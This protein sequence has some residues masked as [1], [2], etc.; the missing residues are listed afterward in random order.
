MEKVSRTKNVVH[1]I[2][3]NTHVRRARELAFTLLM[4]Q[5]RGQYVMISTSVAGRA[6]RVAC[7]LTGQLFPL[8][9]HDQAR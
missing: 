5:G 3:A 2:H 6:L 1:G 9:M 7:N 8:L 4:G